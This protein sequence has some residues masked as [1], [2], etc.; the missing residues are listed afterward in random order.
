MS[1]EPLAVPPRSQQA[2]FQRLRWNLLRNSTRVLFSRGSVRPLSIALA[3][4]VIA[5][6]VFF[7]S[8]AGF[9]F[10][11]VEMHLPLTGGIVGTLV[12]L[13]FLTLGV[14]LIFSTGLILYGSLFGAPESAFL[15]SHPLA[16]DQIFAYKFQGAAGFSSWAF[17]LLGGPVLVAF[18]VVAAA[19]WYFYPFLLLFFLGFV[20]LPASVGA[21]LCLL[22]VNWVP[23]RRLQVMIVALVLL[24]VGLGWWTWSMVAG[25]QSDT[26][27]REAINRLLGRF[28]FA[29]SALVPSH[30]VALGLQAAARA[31]A[32]TAGYYL[33]LVWSNGLVLY[34]LTAWAAGSLYRRGVNRLATGGTIRRRHGGQWLDRL[35]G[36]AL[37]FVDGRTRLLIV[38]DFRTFRRDPQQWGQVLIFSL[39]MLLYATNIRRMSDSFMGWKFLNAISLLN[40][41]VIALLLSIYTS[42]FIYPMLS[43][44]GRKFWVLGLLP[45][46]REQLLWGKFL[47]A[48]SGCLLMSVLLVL[49]S[50]WTLGTPWQAVLLHVAAVVSL[51]IGLSGLS[52]GM[53]A[54]LPNFR[55]TDPSK[56]A[57]GFG[58]TMNL[59][60]SLVFLML[61]LA[62]M[63][64]PWHLQV[65]WANTPD[66]LRVSYLP[67][68]LG[69]A[70]GLTLGVAAV[71]VPLRLGSRALRD[72]EF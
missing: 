70:M 45:L 36:A 53:G 16:D 37:P 25:D 1:A 23:R 42:R 4:V 44:E 66:E 38:K 51:S 47:F 52:V 71:A 22:V 43:L 39:L 14:M 48:A 26:W 19:P 9:R 32:G 28:F 40:L 55:E 56:I 33:A 65:L 31:Q 10:L 20:L 7:V 41:A 62:T 8:W 30:W 57:V 29:R 17:L 18:G 50:D 64:G 35:V 24:T 15:L 3:C 59:I 49:L 34:L 12:D 69:A 61:V 60:L 54:C 46:K 68:I 63:G 2:L 13:L 27:D 58:G 21:L 67:V 11:R 5:L 6:F 72:T